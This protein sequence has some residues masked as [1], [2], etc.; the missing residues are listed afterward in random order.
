MLKLIVDILQQY[1]LNKKAAQNITFGK[2]IR[3]G[4]LQKGKY[5]GYLRGDLLIK[6]AIDK[7]RKIK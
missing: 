7:V 5:L 3:L 2:E 6:V 4:K 1:S